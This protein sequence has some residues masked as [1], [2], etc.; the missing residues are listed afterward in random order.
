[1]ISKIIGET[2]TI[3]QNAFLFRDS[4]ECDP[5]RELSRRAFSL[6]PSNSSTESF[7]A[8]WKTANWP[9]TT[10]EDED[11]RP[12]DRDVVREISKYMNSVLCRCFTNTSMWFIMSLPNCVDTAM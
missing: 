5:A 2:L 6:A 3:I 4:P 8:V 1:M 12:E 11:D 7:I 10:D 9:N